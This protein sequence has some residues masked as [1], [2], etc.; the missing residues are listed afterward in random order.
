MEGEVKRKAVR[1]TKPGPA[2][3]LAAIV[4]GGAG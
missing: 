4:S 2:L 3:L 1:L